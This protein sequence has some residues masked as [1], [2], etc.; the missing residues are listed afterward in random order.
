[1]NILY[2]A[3]VRIPDARA[4]GLAIA[5]QCEAFGDVGHT[6]TLAAPN[7]YRVQS[8]NLFSHYGIRK[9]FTLTY[10]PMI[11][12][13]HIWEQGFYLARLTEMIS[14]FYFLLGNAAKVDVIYA[15]DQ[16]MLLLP[17]F[18]GFQNR[19]VI[20]M[21]TKHSN[22]AVRYVLKRTKKIVVIS[23]GLQTFYEDLVGR[24]DI[25]WA[26]SGVNL[27]QFNLTQTKAELRAHFSL[28]ID[29]FIYGYVGKYSSFNENK[30]VDDI[31]EAFS[32]TYQQLPNTHLLIAGLEER[33]F[34]VVREVLARL[35]IPQSAVSLF[36]LEQDKFSQYVAV[37]DILLMNYPNTEHYAHYMSPT[38]LFAY[39]AT[40]YP[41]ISSDLPSVRDIANDELITFVKP[42]DVIEYANAMVEACGEFSQLLTA[43]EK[44]K[45]VVSHFEWK[46]RVE[47]I[48]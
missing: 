25:V 40:G 17:I 23:R 20:E 2:I 12:I 9:V 1:M 32:I 38:K 24:K 26:P 47:K 4:A 35:N 44:R 33:E 14:S 11:D 8:R 7:R 43:A 27:E 30:G 19:C 13:I 36:T 6:L 41:I 18:F 10:Y 21:H 48:I 34:P 22:W 37:A 39:L 28:P 29:A 3:S 16:W 5:R 46:K 31:I 42:N 15:R 45:E